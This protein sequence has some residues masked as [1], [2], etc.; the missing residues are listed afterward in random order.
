MIAFPPDDSRDENDNFLG[1]L[2]RV[3]LYQVYFLLTRAPPSSA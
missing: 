1:L 3:G 2:D